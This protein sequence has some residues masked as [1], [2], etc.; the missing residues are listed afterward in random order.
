MQNVTCLFTWIDL[1]SY[2]YPGVA[3]SEAEVDLSLQVDQGLLCTVDKLLVI[4]AEFNNLYLD[5]KQVPQSQAH[6]LSAV[7]QLLLELHQVME[8]R[9]KEE[10]AES[11]AKNATILTMFGLAVSKYR[12]CML[13]I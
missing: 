4:I 12:Q 8:R 7:T 10:L 2:L 1:C 9:E 13:M 6:T 3:I 5:C 11:M